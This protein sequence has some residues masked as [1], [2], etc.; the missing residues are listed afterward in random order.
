MQGYI[1]GQKRALLET[2]FSFREEGVYEDKY[3]A[4]TRRFRNDSSLNY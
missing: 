2:I 4:S 1:M 3:S